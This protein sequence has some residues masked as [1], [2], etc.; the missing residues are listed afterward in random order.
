MHIHLHVS[1]ATLSRKQSPKTD[2]PASADKIRALSDSIT[3]FAQSQPNPALTRAALWR[4]MRR[5]AMTPAPLPLTEIGLLLASLVQCCAEEDITE[6][7][8]R[9]SE[10]LSAFLKKQEISRKK[11]LMSL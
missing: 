1:N 11:F 10:E 3:A 2:K 5:E 7:N 8:A 4:C 9:Q 6:F